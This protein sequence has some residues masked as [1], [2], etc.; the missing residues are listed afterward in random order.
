MWVRVGRGAESVSFDE[1]SFGDFSVVGY[2]VRDVNLWDVYIY[3]KKL[4]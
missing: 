2:H 3:M 1:E 4:Y